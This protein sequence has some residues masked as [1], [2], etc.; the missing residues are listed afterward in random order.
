MPELFCVICGK[1][2]SDGGRID[3]RYCREACRAKAYRQRRRQ[4]AEAISANPADNSDASPNNPTDVLVREVARLSDSLTAAHRKVDALEAETRALRHHA[5][6][7]AE[8]QEIEHRQ[9][10]TLAK[11]LGILRAAQSPSAPTIQSSPI[12]PISSTV[13]TQHGAM[14]PENPPIVTHAAS[15]D[16]LRISD[17][18]TVDLELP[19][20]ES[21]PPWNMA[22]SPAEGGV[23]PIWTRLDP[24]SVKALDDRIKS[25]LAT[26]GSMLSMLGD[27]ESMKDFRQAFDPNAPDI[28][29]FAQAVARRIICTPGDQR[30]T[31]EQQAALGMLM[32]RDLANLPPGQDPADRT[33]LAQVQA[34]GSFVPVLLIT[35]LFISLAN[36]E[37]VP[38][39]R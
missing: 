16:P 1:P 3:R 36:I 22:V 7:L 5:A 19:P 32:L 15:P 6:A 21:P 20:L 10:E 29:R 30:Q 33:A 25:T 8:R 9:L 38:R 2:L 4:S 24:G 17:P 34:R 35:Y 39:T 13:L 28:L 26:A 14:S 27:S 11:E 23:V 12:K 37:A 18:P 31:Q